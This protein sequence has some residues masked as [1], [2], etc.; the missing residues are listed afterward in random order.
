MS[1]LETNI[2]P[3]TDSGLPEVFASVESE[4]RSYCR[5]WPTTF[6]TAQ[7]P[8][9][10]DTTGRRYLDFFA[11]AGALNYG[12][13]NPVLKRAVLDYLAGDGIVHSLDM[14]TTAKREFLETFS[15][16][17]LEPPATSTTRSSSPPGR[18][19]PTPSNR[20]SNSP[21]R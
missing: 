14:A 16:L 10:T 17:V 9:L 12:H 18:R 6:E 7:G 13:N 5:N 19:A 4:V 11:G 1:L 8:W 20:R 3:T 15:A 21:A 2:P